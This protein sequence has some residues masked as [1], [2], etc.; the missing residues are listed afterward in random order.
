MIAVMALATLTVS[1]QDSKMAVGI[2]ANYG[3]SSDYKNFGFGAKFQYEFIENFRAEASG[4]YFL[5][6]D[7]M[8]IWD[9]NLNFHY[10]I[11]LGDNLKVYPLAGI[12]LMGV[13]FDAGDAIGSVYDQ[14]KAQYIAAGGSAADF[15]AYWPT[16][17]QEAEAMYKAAG[18]STSDTSIGFNAGAGIEYYL[19]PSFKINLEAKY[20]YTKNADWPVISIGAA[21]CF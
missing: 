21:Y 3:M 20:Q 18:G 12:T 4:D 5:K 6:K 7:G 10:L 15:D 8:S 17:K 11:P 14:A 19:S 2:N 16:I 9:A 13:K 1:A